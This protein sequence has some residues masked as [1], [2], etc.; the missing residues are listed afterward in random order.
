MLRILHL[1]DLHLGRIFHGESLIEDQ[2]HL[3]DQLIALTAKNPP[4]AVLLSGDI[5]DRA[6]PPVE[7]VKLFDRLLSTLSDAG[8]TVV[9]I[10]GNH[11][12]AGRMAYA[13]GAWEKL[14][15]HIRADYQRLDEPVNIKSRDGSSCDI[16]ALPF[17]E[18]TR[19][20]SAFIKNAVESM[21]EARKN[22]VQNQPAILMAH[23]FVAGS[24][25]SGSERLYVG[26]S[27]SVSGELFE[28]FDYVALGHIHSAQRAG[29]ETIR[30]AGSPMAY[31][32]DEGSKEKGFLEIILDNG[33]L[34][35]EVNF[36]PLKPFRSMEV[37][38]DSLDNLLNNPDYKGLKDS[39]ISARV[40]DPLS[41][42]N[43]IGRLRERFPYL[44]ELR[45]T[46]L[47]PIAA[48]NSRDSAALET[49]ASVMSDFLN[50]TGW[51]DGD[52]RNIAEELLS[53]ALNSLEARQ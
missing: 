9:A 19:D 15:V 20:K 42:M 25:E 2:A 8:I 17:V 44:R 24:T 45:Q 4:D 41:H 48:D 50:R 18:L 38:E 11:D 53:E 51:E 23:E 36:I 35:P 3:L 32:F 10:P 28:G 37:L 34:Y 47:E 16:F 13:A 31:A 6:L 26:G 5:Y 43:L 33:Q 39:Y 1:A 7:A 22:N 27:Q 14:G 52:E 30:Y 46:A 49:P 12:S 21:M 29:D 40:T